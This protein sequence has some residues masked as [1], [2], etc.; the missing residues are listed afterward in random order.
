MTNYYDYVSS[1]LPIAVAH[2]CLPPLCLFS[3]KIDLKSDELKFLFELI[4]SLMPSDIITPEFM[5]TLILDVSSKNQSPFFTWVTHLFVHANYAHMLNN[6]TA[7]LQFGFPVYQVFGSNGM[8]A[9]FICGGAISS[10]PSPLYASG[11]AV[12]INDFESITTTDNKYLPSFIKSTWNNNMKLLSKKLADRFP[13]RYVGSSGAVCAF[14]GAD[15]IILLNDSVKIL[16]EC[17]KQIENNQNTSNT[18]IIG[19]RTWS[20]WVIRLISAMKSKSN[21]TILTMNVLNILRSMSYI[22]SEINH[23]Y[24]KSDLGASSR[25]KL[26]SDTLSKFRVNHVAHIQ[27]AL[28]GAGVAGLFLIVVPAV[29][30]FFS[31]GTGKL[32]SPPRRTMQL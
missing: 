19:R 21:A 24:G 20:Q 3:G 12:I 18:L 5:E 6:L 30:K 16:T 32:P 7:A 8:Y 14:I 29:R 31:S 9:L 1:F 17:Q 15:L 4:Y 25:L 27:G 13:T 22:T 23:V 28:V 2:V 11:K 10:Y 26:L